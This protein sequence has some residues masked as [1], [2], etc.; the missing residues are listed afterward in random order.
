MRKCWLFW[1]PLI[2]SCV[3]FLDSD[4]FYVTEELILTWCIKLSFYKRAKCA[5]VYTCTTVKPHVC[6]SLNEGT[7]FHVCYVTVSITIHARSYKILFKF[8]ECPF[9][10]SSKLLLQTYTNFS[11]ASFTKQMHLYTGDN[12]FYIMYAKVCHYSV[13]DCSRQFVF[14]CLPQCH[15]LYLQIIQRIFVLKPIQIIN[16]FI[17]QNTC[18]S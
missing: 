15:L 12:L 11:A 16:A 3:S 2:L 10:T 7:H 17:P 6:K 13:F 5:L 4:L 1:Q 14:I 9:W 18:C 8:F